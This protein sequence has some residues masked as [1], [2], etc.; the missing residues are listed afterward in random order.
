MHR[1]LERPPE[2]ACT[3]IS[4]RTLTAVVMDLVNGPI[5]KDIEAVVT[6]QA[7]K[8]PRRPTAGAGTSS[9]GSRGAR[10]TAKDC[11]SDKVQQKGMMS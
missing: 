1:T 10:P 5:I 6:K 9:G 3:R 7:Y 4:T 11:G 8:T 2:S